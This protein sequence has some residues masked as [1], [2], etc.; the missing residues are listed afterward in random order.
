ML[1]FLSDIFVLIFW[2]DA[3]SLIWVY[4]YFLKDGVLENLAASVADAQTLMSLYFAL[5]TKVNDYWLATI[6]V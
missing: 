3:I 2:T 4:L 5:C 1:S 6:L